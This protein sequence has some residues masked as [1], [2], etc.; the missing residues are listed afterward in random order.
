M[1]DLELKRK[2][3]DH[4]SKMERRDRILFCYKRAKELNCSE[5]N[6]D[7]LSI[8][9]DIECTYERKDNPAYDNYLNN[10]RQTKEK[11]LALLYNKEKGNKR[12][13]L[14]NDAQRHFL[15]D[16]EEEMSRNGI[17]YH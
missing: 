15:W 9:I 7:L 12:V 1:T 5:A 8:L 13:D 3:F 14:F 4:C 10:L 11:Q 6:I 17:D 16:M 2:F